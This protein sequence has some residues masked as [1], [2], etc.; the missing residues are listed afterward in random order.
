MVV[1]PL[2]HEVGDATL[3]T[4]EG[5]FKAS[6]QWYSPLDLAHLFSEPRGKLHDDVKSFTRRIYRMRQIN[7]SSS[8]LISS[9]SLIS[10]GCFPMPSTRSSK[11]GKFLSS[12]PS[13]PKRS[14]AAFTH[15]SSG[16]KMIGK[17][18]I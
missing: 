14:T 1:R 13:K 3:R 16:L 6:R 17:R 7:G 12:Q 5:G 2:E 15:D 9:S 4:S 11:F 8:A 18:Q 10:S